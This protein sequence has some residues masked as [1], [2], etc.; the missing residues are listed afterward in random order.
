MKTGRG[1]ED[2]C[3][4]PNMDIWNWTF[5]LCELQEFETAELYLRSLVLRFEIRSHPIAQIAL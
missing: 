4:P 5:P 1:S 3:E 2:G